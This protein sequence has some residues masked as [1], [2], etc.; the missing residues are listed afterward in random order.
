MLCSIRKECFNPSKRERY[1]RTSNKK[2]KS[3][4]VINCEL[5]KIRLQHGNG[6]QVGKV[7]LQNEAGKKRF[8]VENMPLDYCG[9]ESHGAIGYL[10]DQCLTNSLRKEKINR[11]VVPFITQVTVNS[12]NEA[13]KNPTKPI[14]PYYT[15]EEADIYAKETGATFR[16][17]PKGNDY[18]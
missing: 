11:N 14:G 16:E 8:D 2:C 12:N 4:N 1:I 17:D 5:N 13:F 7:L 6:P 3:Y 18:R 15:K 10:L 9:A